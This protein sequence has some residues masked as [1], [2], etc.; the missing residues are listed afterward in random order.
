[1]RSVNPE[2]AV[3]DLAG[4]TISDEG[5]VLEAFRL[6]MSEV[7][8]GPADPR[9]AAMVELVV[10]TMG[11]SK[12]SVFTMLCDGDMHLARQANQAFEEAYAEL[13]EKGLAKPIPGAEQA[14][15]ALRTNGIKVALTTGFS[16][17][18]RD[19]LLQAVGW[20]DLADLVLSPSDAGR[21]RPY[22]DMPLAALM[23]L[24]GSAVERLMVVGDTMADVASGLAAGAGTVV[25]V[26]TGTH[27][28]FE[29]A[30]AGAHHVL[31]SV[32]DLPNVVDMTAPLV[33]A[34][35]N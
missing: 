23:R 14:I 1:M 7:G 32:T 19:L 3:L 16:P 22:P 4:T 2:I 25:G 17:K 33:G 18:T 34:G 27:N 30:G 8:I 6:A 10:K 29:L 35:C 5:L 24:G 21:G 9:Y 12:I 31:P 15:R 13:L 28:E 11:Q 20:S 26:L